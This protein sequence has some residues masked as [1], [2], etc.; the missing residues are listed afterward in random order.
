MFA[1]DF[2]FNLPIM[3]LNNGKASGPGNNY[4]K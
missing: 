4:L 3:S 2:K 1:T